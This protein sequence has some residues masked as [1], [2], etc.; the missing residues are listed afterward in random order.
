MKK[1]NYA[2]LKPD[3]PARK[4]TKYEPSITEQAGYQTGKQQVEKLL[5]A[6]YNLEM[7]RREMYHFD[8]GEEIPEGFFDPTVDPGF[9]RIDAF[10]NMQDLRHKQEIAINEERMRRDIIN[11]G[12]SNPDTS[13]T[14]PN[15]TSEE[16][17]ETIST[18]GT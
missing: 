16:V 4:A 3:R 12:T 1:Y 11:A 10:E 17:R 2:D 14:P 9:D 15:E 18:E 8:Y 5:R 6:G 7:A 13:N